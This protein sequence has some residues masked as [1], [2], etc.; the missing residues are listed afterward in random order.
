MAKLRYWTAG[1]SHGP[2]LVGIIE[3]LPAG[4]EID[5]SE[6]NFQLWRRQQGYGRGSRMKIEKDEAIILSG[7]RNGKTLGSPI[8]VMIKNRDWEN[9]QKIMNVERTEDSREEKKVTIPRP[10]HADLPGAQ[11]Y[12][13]QDLRNVLERASARETAM[14]VALGAIARQ[15][16]KIFGIK[17]SSHVTRI[18]EA[19]GSFSLI[20]WTSVQKS[21]WEEK[22]TDFSNRAE[23]SPV[24]C[25]QKEIEQKMIAKI[26][27]AKEK[28][29]S[30][31]GEIEIGAFFVPPGLGSHVH[32]DRKLDGKIAAAMMSIP[33]IKSV[34]IGAGKES[35]GKF[36]SEV[37]DEIFMDE[38]G[39][40][41]RKT[42]R[43]GGIEGGISNGEPIIAR[44]TM[45]PIPTL[46]TPLRSVDLQTKRPVSAHKERSDVC[47]VPAA[48]VV[49]EAVLALVLAD[50]YCEKFGGD[51]IA[52]MKKNFE[53]YVNSLEI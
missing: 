36:G 26:D 15:L 46:M 2:A 34:E 9:W 21:Q 19:E 17:I 22:L 20:E 45:K 23:K 41:F 33:A 16:L 39:K 28:G 1:E 51:F 6:I 4:L 14:R 8:A 43:A 11:K 37:H 13:H 49:G 35:G 31:G 53:N 42:N 29:E 47:A 32:W 12:G 27:Q 48:A 10:G 5:I 40:L 3:G 25:I 18:G 7:V 50:V 24:R 30:L 44:C 38:K 52:E